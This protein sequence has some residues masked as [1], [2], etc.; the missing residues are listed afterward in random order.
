MN[1]E[2]GFALPMAIFLL[3]ILT[4]L[5]TWLM[6][7]TASSLSA[8]ALE[9]EGE[10]AYQAAQSGLEAGIYAAR[11]NGSCASQTVSFGG[12]LARFKAAVSCTSYTANEGGETV[13]LYAITS[14]ACNQPTCPN[15][16]PSLLEYAE[17]QVS[18][19]VEQ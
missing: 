16:A 1:R 10:R 19:K 17:R 13:T 6:R 8:D 12:E 15:A 2:R 5:A 14:I 3:V 7:I 4:A 11:V 9:L 18:A